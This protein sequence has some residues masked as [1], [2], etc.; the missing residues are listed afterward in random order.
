MTIVF[1]QQ[2]NIICSKIGHT[3]YRQ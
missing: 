1:I 2:H 3:G